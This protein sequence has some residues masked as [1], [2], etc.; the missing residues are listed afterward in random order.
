MP[1][2]SKLTPSAP[3]AVDAAQ[4][5]ASVTCP[6]VTFYNA[7]DYK[8]YDSVAY[9]MR[10]ILTLTAHAVERELAS[11]GLTNAQW[12]P[13]FKLHMGQ[14]STV[15]ELARECDLD[16]GAMTRMLDRLEAKQ[17]C[18]RERS[19]EDRR[20]V[21]LVLTDSGRVAAK[22]IPVV[23]SRVQNAHLAGFSRDE[24]ELLRTFLQR[25][26]QTAQQSAHTAADT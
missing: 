26:L 2:R 19:L 21:N 22:R 24:W 8:P 17:L 6:M 13:L 12:V 20:V 16:T 23:L 9:L 25:I 18:R 1:A 10:R 4:L 5:A 15:A 14:A 11:T 7:K 3:L